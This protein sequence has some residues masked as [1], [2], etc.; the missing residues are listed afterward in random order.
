[1]SPVKKRT[2]PFSENDEGVQYMSYALRLQ[3]THPSTEVHALSCSRS[4]KRTCPLLVLHAQLRI[5]DYPLSD[6][7]HLRVFFCVYELEGLLSSVRWR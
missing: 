4:F 2:H 3:S 1:M 6:S 5:V 7:L